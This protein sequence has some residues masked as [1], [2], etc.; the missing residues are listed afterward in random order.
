MLSIRFDRTVLV[1]SS[2]NLRK[3]AWKA[4]LFSIG[5]AIGSIHCEL[6]DFRKE[7]KLLNL[8]L[9][10]MEV[11]NVKANPIKSS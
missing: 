8:N 5:I 4:M 10:T 7:I 1:H 2:R 11:F 3:K 9:F 6:I